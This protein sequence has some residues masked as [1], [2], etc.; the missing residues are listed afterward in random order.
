MFRVLSLLS[1]AVVVTVPLL[2]HAQSAERKGGPEKGTWAAEAS[3]GGSFGQSSGEGGSLLRFVSPST[4]IVGGFGFSRSSVESRAVNGEFT[5]VFNAAFT[6]TAV[7]VGLRRYAGTG[8][9]LRPV[10]GGGLLFA[11]QSVD[12]ASENNFGGYAEGGAAWFFNPHVSLGV[13]GGVSAAKQRGGW[14]AGGSLARLTGTVY[15]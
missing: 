2:A 4:A 6:T 8:L 3:V 11:R 13:L 5:S 14:S 9:G 12:D 10:L 1:C 7:Q 15:F